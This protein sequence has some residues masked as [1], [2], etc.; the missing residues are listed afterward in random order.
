MRRGVF[1][2]SALWVLAAC[3]LAVVS[4]RG[5]DSATLML[6]TAQLILILGLVEDSYRLAY[7][8]ELTGLPGRRALNEALRS[9][10]GDY[11]IAMIDVDRFKRFNDR[12]G[13]ETGDQALRMVAECLRGVGGGGRAFRYGGEEFTVL[14]ATGTVPHAREVVDRLRKT[15]AARKFGLRAPKRPRK[16]PHKPPKRK[17]TARQVTVTVSAGVAGPNARRPKA[18]DVLRAADR[19]LYRAKN[20]GRNRVKAA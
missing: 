11:A 12:Y 19:A 18:E 9:L 14:F 2:S 20:A 10:N 8:D 15:I 17:T 5:V 16:K 6:A 4:G 7:H 3:A 13:H 1:E